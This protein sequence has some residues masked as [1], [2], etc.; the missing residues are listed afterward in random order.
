MSASSSW[1]R[2]SVQRPGE[3]GLLAD[4]GTQDGLS[5]LHEDGIRLAHEVDDDLGR[6][7]QEGLP[8][9]QQAPVAHGPPDDAA[10]H[11]AAPLVGGQDAVGDEEGDGPRVVGDDLV[12]EALRLEGVRVVAHELAHAGVDGR[13]EVGVVVGG[14]ALQ[15][16]G[17][18]LQA[19]ARVH[20]GERQRQARA[21]SG[22][23]SNS[24]KTRFQISSQRGQC[25]LWSG[26]QSGPS[27]SSAPRS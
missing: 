5:T 7:G 27:E 23:W 26:T 18:A 22:C 6:L 8:P 15:D 20:R 21:P 24:M 16:G 12:A 3:G 11:V 25:S 19:H 17:Q 9:T 4:D 14:H 10:Q 1:T 13:E 2:A